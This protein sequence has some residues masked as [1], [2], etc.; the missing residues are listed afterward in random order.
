MEKMSEEELLI[1]EKGTVSCEDFEGLLGELVEGEL[2]PTVAEKLHHH[3]EECQ[4]CHDGYELY[5]QVIDIARLI[6][7]ERQK[8]PSAMPDEVK[9]RL[10]QRLNAS[11]GLR[12]S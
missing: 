8:E 10:H 7:K 1:L 11:L 4:E 2:S 5:E 6:G 12:L 9:K 3:C